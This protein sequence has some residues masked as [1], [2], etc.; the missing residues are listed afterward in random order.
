MARKE[1]VLSVFVASPSDVEEERNR[2]EDAIRELNTTLARQF[3]IRLNLIRWETHAFPSFGEDPQ[4]VINEQVPQDYDLFIGIMWYRFGTRTGRAGSGTVEEFKRAKERHD[5]NPNDVQIMI[6]FKDAPAPVPPSQLDPEQLSGVS[7]FRSSL[8]SLGGL[9]WSFQTADDFEK[10][11]RIHLQLFIQ[12]WQS[13]T[14]DPKPP[15]T[16]IKEVSSSNSSDQVEAEDTGLLDLAEQFED[17]FSALEEVTQ[18]IANAMVEV[19]EKMNARTAETIEFTSGPDAQ[20]RKAAKRLISKAAADMD[21]Y[22]LRIKSELPL[23]SQHLNAGVNALTRAVVL[24]VEINIQKEDVEQAKDAVDE[25]GVL[26]ETMASTEEQLNAFK[27][28]VASIPPMTTTLNRSKRTMVNVLQRQ[29][30]ELRGAQV[31][32]REAET[33]FAL[34]GNYSVSL[35]TET[36]AETELNAQQVHILKTLAESEGNEVTA[37][38]V[39][40]SLGEN[41]S[42]VKHYLTQL[43]KDEY[44]YDSLA[45]GEEPKYSIADRGREYLVEH[46]LL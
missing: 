19:G 27:E 3:P 1:T 36:W 32:L 45:I 46:N 4:A 20:N 25:I 22:V 5:A 28:T 18:R 44:A 11:V 6:Y 26:Q 37:E 43:V 13:R 33:S 12:E 30:D 34:I 15:S 16:P 38:T 39:A 31:M 40:H 2:L 24:S 17:E 42:R 7:E 29:I 10:L 23:F 8:G 35:P 21:Q 14:L 9:Y 41:L